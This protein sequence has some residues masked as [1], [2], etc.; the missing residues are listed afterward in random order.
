MA[1]INGQKVISVK[2]NIGEESTTNLLH[3]SNIKK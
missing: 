2:V 1:Y 3:L